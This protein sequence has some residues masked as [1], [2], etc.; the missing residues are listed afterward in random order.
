MMKNEAKKNP[1][2]ALPLQLVKQLIQASIY[3]G[4][5][6]SGLNVDKLA[7]NAEFRGMKGE[8]LWQSEPL[9]EVMSAI[10]QHFATHPTEPE[11]V[12]ASLNVL[13]RKICVD[14]DR[15]RRCYY[16]IPEP[17]DCQ[18]KPTE[19]TPF[20]EA[21]MNPA[22]PTVLDISGLT[23]EAWEA[24]TNSAK[25]Q[26]HDAVRDGKT[27]IAKKLARTALAAVPLIL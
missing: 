17:V 11:K 14:L 24:L 4:F 9:G 1:E 19:E 22:L 2:T 27:D 3:E 26:I 23:K 20:A 6:D 16:Q 15:I 7:Q 18:K 5:L 10:R 25:K 21:T 12:D 8:A 13:A